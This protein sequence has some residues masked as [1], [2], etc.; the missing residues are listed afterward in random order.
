MPI[1][2]TRSLLTDNQ[3]A[4]TASLLTAAVMMHDMCEHMTQLL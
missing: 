1:A 3:A 2:L 4:L